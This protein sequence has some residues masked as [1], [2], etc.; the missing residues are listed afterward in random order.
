MTDDRNPPQIDQEIQKVKEP[1]LLD[2][3]SIMDVSQWIA[4]LILG[5]MKDA[6]YDMAKDAVRDML[7]S[8]KRR[9]GKSRVRDLEAK[10]K[11]LIGKVKTQSDL[12]DDEIAVRL[13]EIFKDFR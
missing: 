8:M 10:V 1:H 12:N 6:V 3:G 11:D 2:I 5:L 4:L 13:S 9:F 7:N